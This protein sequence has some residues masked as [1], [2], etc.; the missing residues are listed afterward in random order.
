MPFGERNV[1]RIGRNFE[2]GVAHAANEQDAA[3]IAERL[4]ASTTTIPGLD[5]LCRL[6]KRN[7]KLDFLHVVGVPLEFTGTSGMSSR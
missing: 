2:I 5:T 6:E 1:A 7:A 4:A 3:W